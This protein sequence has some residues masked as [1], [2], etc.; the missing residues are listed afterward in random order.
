MYMTPLE[1]IHTF[2]L[3]LQ[4]LVKQVALNPRKLGDSLKTNSPLFVHTP[5]QFPLTISVHRR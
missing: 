3:A 5:D 4:C 2:S 1:H